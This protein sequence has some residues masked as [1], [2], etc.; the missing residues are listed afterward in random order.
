M[1]YSNNITTISLRERL[2]REPTNDGPVIDNI[3][4]Q[5]TIIYIHYN[6]P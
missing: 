5:Q 3:S 2:H 4:K 1:I 6:L